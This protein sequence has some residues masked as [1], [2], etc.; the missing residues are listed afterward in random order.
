MCGLFSFIFFSMNVF[1]GW[2]LPN[3]PLSGVGD[4]GSY[5]LNEPGI[6]FH[7][8]N[9][10]YLGR[11][12]KLMTGSSHLF[13]YGR[14]SNRRHGVELSLQRRLTTPI[15]KTRHGEIPLDSPQGVYADQVETRLG[16]SYLNNNFKMEA[17]VSYEHYGNLRGEKILKFLHELAG[18]NIYIN[19]YGEK[20]KN[21]YV[22]G[23]VGFGYLVGPSLLMVYFRESPVMRDV[24]A[25]T[26]IK[27][28]KKD[29]Q[30]SIQAEAARQTQSDFY[31]DD[32]EDWRYGYGLSFKLYWYQMSVNYTS[33]YLSYDKFGQFYISPLIVSYEF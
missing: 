15:V 13:L 19:V 12:D 28:G 31:R 8:H 26:N 11:T 32:I 10:D 30:V 29:I 4:S 9:N 22:S 16:Y 23:A 25:R 1:A 14:S 3:T 21:D 2:E 6:T 18:S 20:I 27:F 24:M 5:Y 33:K 17:A 7:V